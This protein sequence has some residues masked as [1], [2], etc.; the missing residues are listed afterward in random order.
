MLGDRLKMFRKRA[1]LT[2]QDVAEKLG[3]SRPAVGQWESGAT[4]PSLD[5]LNT[6]AALY[7]ASRAVL[8][9]DMPESDRSNIEAAP[10][11]GGMAPLISWIQAGAFAE[12]VIE[13]NEETEFYPRPSNSSDQTFVLRVVGESMIDE[14]KP[15]TLIFVDPE[16]AAVSGDDVIAAMEGTDEATFKRYI[17]EPGIGKMLKALNKGWTDPY[18]KINGNCRIVG[19]VVAAMWLK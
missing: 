13:S 14:Y 18:I 19:V 1:G 16:R 17:E 9:G 10:P 12:S 15:G 3:V 5:A 2:Q 8:L 11:L 7:G 6:L 4:S